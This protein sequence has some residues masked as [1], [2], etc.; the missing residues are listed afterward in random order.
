M[1][2]LVALIFLANL[3]ELEQNKQTKE[4]ASQLRSF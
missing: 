3:A 2:F 1:F 4:I